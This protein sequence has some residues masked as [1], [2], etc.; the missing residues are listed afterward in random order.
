[1]TTWVVYFGVKDAKMAEGSVT[2]SR[3]LQLADE[4]ENLSKRVDYYIDLVSTLELRIRELETEK[5][6]LERL[7]YG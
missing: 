4:C 3:Y 6:R 5:D 7:T 1:M 2:F